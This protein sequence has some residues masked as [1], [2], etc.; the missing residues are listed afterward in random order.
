MSVDPGG[1]TVTPEMRRAV[2]AAECDRLGHEYSVAT[3]VHFDETG[4][5]RLVLANA[6]P[7]KAPHLSCTRC[8]RVWLVAEEGAADYPT[9]EQAMIGR[10]PA[11]DTLRQRLAERR[12]RRNREP[13]RAP[14]WP[15]PAR[16][17]KQP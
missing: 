14:D 3:A 1:I 17:E 5:A 12:E 11:D 16:E 15:P 6:D 13:S 4:G 7:D 9:A 10:L 8:E 2:L